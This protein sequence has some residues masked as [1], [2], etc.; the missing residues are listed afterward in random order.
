MVSEDREYVE[1][2]LAGETEVFE[3]LVSK[4]NRMA[5]AIAFGITGSFHDAEDVV[6]EAFLKAFR[7]LATLRDPGK[8]KYWLAGLVKTRALD[9]LRYRRSHR[10]GSLA[11]GPGVDELAAAGTYRAGGSPEE[12]QVREETRRKVLEALETLP[13]EDRLVLS[14]K[15]MEG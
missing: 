1:R 10:E 3:A 13:T 4:Y 7:L 5:G 15:H 14:L 2:I 6:Q 12:E 11:V 8:F 9:L